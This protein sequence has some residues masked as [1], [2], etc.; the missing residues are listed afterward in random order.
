[1][2]AQVERMK[3]SSSRPG[4]DLTQE[5]ESE[6]LGMLQRLQ[7][8]NHSLLRE[9]DALRAEVAALKRQVGHQG[10][11][12]LIVQR[13]SSNHVLDDA[14]GTFSPDVSDMECIHIYGAR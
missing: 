14:K 11:L 7:A 13:S 9:N 5:L 2:E 12:L 4:P 6:T 8:E 10:F 3:E 1:M